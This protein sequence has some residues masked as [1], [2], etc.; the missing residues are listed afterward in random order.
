[1][2]KLELVVNCYYYYHLLFIAEKSHQDA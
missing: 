2:T 1:M